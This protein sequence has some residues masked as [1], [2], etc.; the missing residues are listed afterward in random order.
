MTEKY[1]E[2]SLE[3]M[4]YFDKLGECEAKYASE[5]RQRCKLQ[6]TVNLLETRLAKEKAKRRKIAITGT[7]KL[8]KG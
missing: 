4:Q 7:A 6:N 8:S 2:A 5:V 1:K 3:R